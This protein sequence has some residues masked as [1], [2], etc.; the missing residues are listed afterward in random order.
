MLRK[1]IFA[2]LI[3]N[4]W[5]ACSGPQ[6]FAAEQPLT[7]DRINFSVSVQEE[8]E[9]DTV[10]AIVYVQREGSETGKLADEVNK[11]ISWAVE[12]A[13]EVPSVKVQTMDYQTFPVY[14]QQT[15]TGWR[16]RQ[17]ISMETEDAAALSELLG[18]LQQ[19]LAIQAISY[20]ISHERRQNVEQKL[21][22]EV[23]ARFTQRAELVTSQLKRSDYRIVS[24]DINT[25]GGPEPHFR[26]SPQMLM[27][28]RS[29]T[30]PALE[31]GTQ[32]LTVSVYG[33]I[34]L[35]VQ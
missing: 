31:S 28:E 32:T 35:Q 18:R 33:T 22:S 30:P 11:E 24:L 25:G 19:R 20:S 27:A 3:I 29:V 2:F 13:K 15:L 7:Y 21:I 9:N 6:S 10:T 8:V 12:R 14:S 26:S 34:E 1:I 23:L 16:V 17:S 5:S 4:L